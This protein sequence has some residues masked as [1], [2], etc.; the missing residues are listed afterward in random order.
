MDDSFYGGPGEPSAVTR[1]LVPPQHAQGQWGAIGQGESR[2]RAALHGKTECYT[3]C[4]ACCA[5]GP[6]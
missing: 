5:G 4:Q 1:G 6:W 2:S 3:L